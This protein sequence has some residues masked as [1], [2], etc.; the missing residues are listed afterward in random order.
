MSGSGIN[1]QSSDPLNVSLSY[2]GSTLTEQ[3]VDTVTNATF[4][5]AYT[6]LNIPAI[7]GGN[8]AFVG[9]GGGTGGLTS[10]QDISAWKYDSVETGATIHTP[11]DLRVT[12][13]DRHDRSTTDVNIAWKAN[14]DFNATGFTIQRSPDGQ[15]FTTIATV[16]P[17]TDSYTD[18]R[19]T[20]GTYF[21]RVQAFNA[22]TVSAF[23]NTDGVLL[24]GGDNTATLDDSA[25]FANH[26]NL[27]ANGSAQFTT[28]VDGVPVARLTDGGATEAGTVFLT[29]RIGVATFN[30]SFTFQQQ[31]GTTRPWQTD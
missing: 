30:T 13:V 14:D 17:N 28:N 27:T 21:Y 31:P 11:T 5:H 18:P 22:T 6:A 25:G 1:L 23:S 8:V 12:S 9:F 26:G 7:V 10:V 4:T 2:D 24:G 3:V 16:G 19:L 15:N 29:P 20:G